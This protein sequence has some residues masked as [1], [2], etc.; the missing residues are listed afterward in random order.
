MNK[1]GT[2][3]LFKPRSHHPFDAK[4]RDDAW[5]LMVSKIGSGG[6]MMV[7]SFYYLFFIWRVI[8]I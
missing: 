1:K 2:Q 8:R 4:D 5:W 3:I 6:V 7:F